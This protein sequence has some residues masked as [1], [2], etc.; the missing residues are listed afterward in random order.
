[1]LFDLTESKNG[2]ESVCRELRTGY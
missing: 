2:V 1:M